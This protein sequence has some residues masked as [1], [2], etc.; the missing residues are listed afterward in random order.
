MAHF[1]SIRRSGA[2]HI[3][4]VWYRWEAGSQ[5]YTGIATVVSGESAIKTRN[6]RRNSKVSLSVATDE[7]PYQYVILE[8]D[9]T[10][11]EENIK[12]TVRSIFSRYEG[13]ERGEEDA[14]ELTEG[15]QR[16][17]SI[18]I[19]VKRVLSWKGDGE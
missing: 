8:G 7:W 2:P 14:N 10:V 12:D 5:P 19:S 15:D 11:T 16:L 17:V 4:P 3:S 6:V 9:A 13:A 1:A 18:V